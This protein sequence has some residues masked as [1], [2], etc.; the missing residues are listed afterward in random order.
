MSSSN[1]QLSSTPTASAASHIF[2]SESAALDDTASVSKD[3]HQPL[4]FAKCLPMTIS[5]LFR[6]NDSPSFQDAV[7]VS[8]GTSLLDNL[9]VQLDTAI[10]DTSAVSSIIS[11]T[12]QCTSIIEKQTAQRRDLQ[13][14]REQ[15]R[16]V[17]STVRQLP[18]EI[19]QQIFLFVPQSSD[20]GMDVFDRRD[21]VYRIGQVCQKWRRISHH[22]PRLWSRFL[23]SGEQASN[24][25]YGLSPLRMVLERSCKVPLDFAFTCGRSLRNEERKVR[26]NS[27]LLSLLMQHSS[28]WRHVE[29]MGM[30]LA[31]ALLLGDVHGRIPLLRSVKLDLC[32]DSVGSERRDMVSAF[33]IAPELS[34]VD[35]CSIPLGHVLLDP[36]AKQNLRY[37]RVNHS[38]ATD[39][40]FSCHTP[41]VSD[42]LRKYP[43]LTNL[44]HRRQSW[45]FDVVTWPAPPPLHTAR[46]VYTNITSLSVAE[47]GSINC[48]SLPNL[49]NLDAGKDGDCFVQGLFPC[50]VSLLQHSRCRLSSL[51]LRFAEWDGDSMG[52]LLS[53]VPD[54]ETLLISSGGLP[55]I[56]DMMS[57]L[58]RFLGEKS[59][60]GSLRPKYAPR[61]KTLDIALHVTIRPRVFP[62]W[63]FTSSEFLSMV[64]IVWCARGCGAGRGL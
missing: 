13:R 56:D 18:P 61:L 37:L 9:I 50:V 10:A 17:S 48:V 35:L 57:A 4:L 29:F 2:A 43:K 19:W 58:T 22:C 39:S 20:D 44:I 46:A 27:Q 26:T 6:T 42:V 51:R 49:T 28:R 53:L 11:L 55:G 1:N 54:L 52:M 47:C 8:E 36:C 16:S 64:G 38:A 59:A 24:S 62:N 45:F 31:E 21:P 34:H 12:A 14:L 7:F 25:S 3:V 15:V 63:A 60:V 32:L 30:S 23:I 41:T 40:R 5:R 33:E